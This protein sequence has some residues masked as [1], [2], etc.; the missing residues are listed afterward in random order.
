MS[1]SDDPFAAA[2]H[3]AHEWLRAVADGL[4]TED[5]SF[6]HRALRAWM[7]VVRDRIGSANS[8]HLSAQ[9]PEVLRGVYYEGWVPSHVPVHHGLAE[10]IDQFAREACIGRDEVGKVAGAITAVLADR[11]SPGQLNRVFAVLPMHLYGILWGARP[12]PDVLSSAPDH[13]VERR[14]ADQPVLLQEQIRALGD[15]VAALAR[16]LEQLP[17]DTGNVDR[18]AAAAQEAHRILLAEGLVPGVREH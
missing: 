8:A 13:R 5:M 1:R 3:T 16:G 14:G 7:H 15:A 18:T 17:I 12:E 10:F 6:A 9:L 4:D 11:F 2:V